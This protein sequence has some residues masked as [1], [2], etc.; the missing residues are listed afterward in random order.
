MP[1]NIIPNK[2]F[3]QDLKALSKK[4]PSVKE[5]INTIVA[6]LKENPKIGEPL[7]KDCYKIRV[8]IRSKGKGKSGGARLITCVKI[9]QSTVYLLSIYDKSDFDSITDEDIKAR[10]KEI[11][12]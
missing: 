4:Y 5:D 1:F 2:S 7:G 9:I 11:K 3:L 6:E 8:L 10:L 12:L